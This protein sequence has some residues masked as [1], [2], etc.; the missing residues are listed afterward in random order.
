MYGAPHDKNPWDASIPASGGLGDLL[1]DLFRGGGSPQMAQHPMPPPRP[2]GAPAQASPAPVARPQPPA[3]DPDAIIQGIVGVPAPA[4]VDP[5]GDVIQSMVGTP[6][7]PG[8]LPHE[9]SPMNDALF[10][11]L[12]VGK[13]PQMR[14]GA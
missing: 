1:R 13:R 6:G 7:M 12:L 2:T 4:Q 14:A 9:L 3:A 10:K 5:L 8:A 11:P